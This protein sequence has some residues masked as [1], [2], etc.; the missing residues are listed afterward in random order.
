MKPDGC[1]A[2]VR[3]LRGDGEEF[4]VCRSRKGFDMSCAALS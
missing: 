3:A 2:L 4:A 1:L